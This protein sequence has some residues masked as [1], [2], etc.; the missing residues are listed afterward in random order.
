MCLFDDDHQGGDRAR[1]LAGGGGQGGAVLLCA[2]LSSGRALQ[3]SRRPL[4]L[5]YQTG[6]EEKSLRFAHRVFQQ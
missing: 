1:E 3:Q 6:V 5:P 2:L 4:V